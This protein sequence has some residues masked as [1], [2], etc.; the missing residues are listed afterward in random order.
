MRVNGNYLEQA[1]AFQGVETSN[2]QQQAVKFD[3]PNDSF[4]SCS[5]IEKPPKINCVRIIFNRLTDEQIE[6]INK[7]GKLPDNAKFVT[8]ESGGYSISPNIFGLTTGTQILPEGF[9]VKKNKLG[10]TVVL[11]KGTSGLLIK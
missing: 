9:E 7:S 10:V 2:V 3:M 4:E 1:T 6:Q 8:N 5:E 11:P